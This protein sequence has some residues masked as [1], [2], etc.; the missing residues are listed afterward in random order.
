MRKKS[1]ISFIF[2]EK[3]SEKQNI[4]FWILL[5]LLALVP[6]GTV[7]TKI[8]TG[9]FP[10]WY[11]PAR[12][13]LS[14][15]SNLSKPT[16]IGPSTG[17]PGIFYGPYWIWLLSFG[18]LFS[19]DPK[20]VDFIVLA[21]PYFII[22]PYV[23]TRFKKVF[24]TKTSLMLWLLFLLGFDTYSFYLWNPHPAPL[25]FLIVVL[26]LLLSRFDAKKI[27]QRLLLLVSGFSLGVLVNFHV[28]FGIGIAVGTFIFFI[29]DAFFTRE[30]K[31]LLSRLLLRLLNGIFFLLGFLVA[32]SPFILFE[33]RHNFS[34]TKTFTNALLHF[35]GV[36]TT[37]G[38]KKNSNN[39]RIF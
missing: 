35:G 20:I 13:M 26:L 4:I 30:K 14:A 15:L 5:L 31:K 12:D 38:L 9:A 32:F 1:S 22:F 11:D 28:S 10:F 27:K 24:S 6:I 2:K 37:S 21:I 36:V 29:L 17:I 7:L 23:L 19:K 39:S 3:L 25:I 8:V 34:Q 33:I 18:Q 16:L